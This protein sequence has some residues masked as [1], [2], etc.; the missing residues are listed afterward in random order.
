MINDAGMTL[1]A[2]KYEEQ[3]LKELLKGVVRV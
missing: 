3:K 1:S 2:G